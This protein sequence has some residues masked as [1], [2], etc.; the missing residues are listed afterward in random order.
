[1]QIINL[2]QDYSSINRYISNTLLDSIEKC[3]EKWKKVILYLNKRWEYA[4]FICSNCNHI[5]HCPNCDINLSVHKKPEK[6]V[7]HLCWYKKNIDLKCEKCKQDTLVKIW[8]WTQDI[9]NSL[10]KYFSKKNQKIKI[11]RF[12]ADNLKNKSSKNLAIKNIE[13]SN[14]IIW[15]KMINTGHD[16]ENI[17]LIWVILLEQELSIPDYKTEERAY[18]NILQ[19]FWRWNRKWEKTI[20]IIQTFIPE[21]EI[22]KTITEWNYK[23]YFKFILEE[24]KLYN[25]PPFCE[26]AI[27]EYKHTNKQKA[28]DFIFNI[29]NKL[30]ILNTR[31]T[32]EII[33]TN[34]SFKKKNNYFYRIILKWKNLRY[35]LENIKMEIIR[36]K[37]LNVVVE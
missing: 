15:T 21:N 27:I 4:S 7:C 16:L 13:S 35:F 5:Y 3:L 1:M 31:N 19:L 34:N 37:W 10:E 22:V 26:Y 25:Y 12:D 28:F 14:I 9:E 30:E 17:W 8:T 36:N 33:F 32:F 6:L 2:N 18:T 23:T 20:N 29:K 11:F 24:R